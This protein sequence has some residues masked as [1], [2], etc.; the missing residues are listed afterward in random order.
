M[1]KYSLFCSNITLLGKK[2]ISYQGRETE[3]KIKITKIL[4]VLLGRHTRE[5]RMET[6][7]FRNKEAK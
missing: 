6:D 5:T 7:Y 1:E 2:N 4:S 3:E